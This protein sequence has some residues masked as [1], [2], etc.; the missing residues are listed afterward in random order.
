MWGEACNKIFITCT[1]HLRILKC[2]ELQIRDPSSGQCTRNIFNNMP[3]KLLSSFFEVWEESKGNLKRI[4]KHAPKHILL[5]VNLRALCFIP[6]ILQPPY[7]FKCQLSS[8]TSMFQFHP[9]RLA[10]ILGKL[11]A[12][13]CLAKWMAATCGGAWS[14]AAVGRFSVC[15]KKAAEQ[16]AVLAVPEQSNTQ[17]NSWSDDHARNQEKL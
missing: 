2:R 9:P 10:H 3:Q 5:R 16:R 4:R 12:G 1:P 15:K 7:F 8:W 14:L 13:N 17:T 11:P 6:M